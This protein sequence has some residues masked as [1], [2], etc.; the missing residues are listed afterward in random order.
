[1]TNFR[2]IF[3]LLMTYFFMT[4]AFLSIK[5]YAAPDINIDA[6]VPSSPEAETDSMIQD[7]FVQIAYPDLYRLAMAYGAISENSA[8]DLD[9][10]LMITECSLYEKFFANEFEWEKIRTNTS[11]YLKENKSKISK[12]YEYVQP[13]YLARYDSAL[14]G[15][16]VVESEKFKG[17]KSLQFADF[18]AGETEC[19]EYNISDSQYPSMA[20][21]EIDSPFTLSFIR[22]PTKLAQTYVEWNNAN[23]TSS[24]YNRK[25][26]IRYRIRID[27]FQGVQTVTAGDLL[28]FTG[29]LLMVDVFA[30]PEMMLPLY[31]QVF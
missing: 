31:N 18:K 11:R 17:V 2:A 6:L 1:M 22:V 19:N 12:Y 5:A 28:T 21:L 26:F 24:G 7:S 14:Q 15:F 8:S 25:A 4:P 13:I 20:A 9:V 23:G 30:D 16:P 27:G 29:K 3:L 10:F